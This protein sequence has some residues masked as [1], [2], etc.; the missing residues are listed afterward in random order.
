MKKKDVYEP[1]GHFENLE[2]M[3]IIICSECANV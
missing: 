1:D 3:F 2:V